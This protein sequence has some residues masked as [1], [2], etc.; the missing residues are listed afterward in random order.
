MIIGIK[1][2]FNVVICFFMIAYIFYITSLKEEIDIIYL[3]KIF[4]NK[5]FRTLIILLIT[6]IS[7]GMEL[8]TPKIGGNYILALFIAISYILTINILKINYI[9]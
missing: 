5:I 7:L 8:G 4:D 1:C 2:I 6:F 9:S 3:T